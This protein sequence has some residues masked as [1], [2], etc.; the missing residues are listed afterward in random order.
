M[1]VCLEL[2]LQQAPAHLFVKMGV[3]HL[4]LGPD[5]AMNAEHRWSLRTGAIDIM[6]AR[7][8]PEC[9]HRGARRLD[10]RCQPP[11]G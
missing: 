3:E 1:N 6:V 4:G 7:N 11:G 10:E 8:Q 9:S 5:G 2:L